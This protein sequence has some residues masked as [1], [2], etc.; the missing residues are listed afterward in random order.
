MSLHK[1]FL[2]LCSHGTNELWGPCYCP[3][4]S[5]TAPLGSAEQYLGD[6]C[7]RSA[8][9]YGNE[10]I[11]ICRKAKRHAVMAH[12][13]LESV[14]ARA[15]I[16]ADAVRPADFDSVACAVRQP[17]SPAPSANV[18]L[19]AYVTACALRQL[20]RLSIDWHES[21]PSMPRSTPAL[22]TFALALYRHLNR[23]D[24][25]RHAGTGC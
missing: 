25:D 11:N 15:V 10:K 16:S 13:R 6:I 22:P 3:I 14:L 7:R 12:H 23:Y 21:G 5:A 24:D 1:R 19:S 2:Q 17:R 18:W 20:H 8:V 4:A 9:S